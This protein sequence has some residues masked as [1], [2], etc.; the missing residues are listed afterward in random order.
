MGKPKKP[1]EVEPFWTEMVGIWFQI[2]WDKFQDK[3]TF[4]GSSPRDLKAIVKALR[5]RTQ[6][7]EIEWTLDV[8]QS[9]LY[10]FFEFAY[11]SSQWLR[12]NWLLSNIN[13]QKDAL[14]FQ[15]STE[16]NGA[17]RN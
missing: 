15:K 2:C 8:A 14:F 17:K 1:K 4:D 5:E 9:R 12:N 6:R 13:R 11:S 3:P 10:K 16:Y 7:I